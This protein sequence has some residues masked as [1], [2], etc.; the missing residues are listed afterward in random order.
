MTFFLVHCYISIWLFLMI[1]QLNLKH[2]S[3]AVCSKPNLLIDLCQFYCY[4]YT[5]KSSLVWVSSMVFSSLHVGKPFPLRA[6]SYCVH[7]YLWF[8]KTK[9]LTILDFLHHVEFYIHMLLV[10]ACLWY[11]RFNCSLQLLRIIF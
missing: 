1:F 8:Q 2:R 9:F 5:W 10:H 4:H 3:T 11:I 7:R 6:P